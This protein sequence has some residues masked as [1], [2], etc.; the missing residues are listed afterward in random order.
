MTDLHEKSQHTDS[1]TTWWITVARTAIIVIVGAVFLASGVLKFLHADSTSY[2]IVSYYLQSPD[3]QRALGCLEVALALWIFS[4]RMP[5][6]AFA[7][8]I[9]AFI[10]FTWIIGIELNKTSPRACGCFE[11]KPGFNDPERIRMG[12]WISVV[13]NII[14]VLISI[15]AILTTP[16]SQKDE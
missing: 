15:F 3:S 8:S 5:R 16:D 1:G 10:A 6:L 14:L 11:L 9:L 12:L 4:V 2:T 13:R 7:V